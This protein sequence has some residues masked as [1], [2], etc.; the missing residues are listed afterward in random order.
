MRRGVRIAIVIAAV[1]A[2][3]IAA[4]VLVPRTGPISVAPTPSASASVS[5]SPTTSPTAS[6]SAAATQSASPTAA[7]GRATNTVL[8]YSIQ[9]PAPWRRTPCLSSG[10][11]PRAPEILGIDTFTSLPVAEESYGDTGALIN[12]LSVRVERNPNRLTAEAWA[13]SPRMGSS[14]GQRIEPATLD[15]RAGVRLVAELL[16][17]ETTIVPVDDLMY[18]VGFTARP[19]DP[20]VATMRAIIASFTF[21]P[22]IQS[23][24]ATTR[25]ARSAEAVADGLATGFA[26]QDVTALQGLMGECFLSGAE[27][28]GFGSHSPERFAR[29]LREQFAAGTT[30]IV[31]PRP[32]ESTPGF[33]SGPTFSIAT[34][35]TDPAQ[36]PM[37]VDLII[38]ADGPFHYWR[39]TIR[40]Q[41]SP[42]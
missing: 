20:I 7:S 38:A 1:A 12:T 41:Q 24:A 36:Q 33:A 30:V 4:I 26:N 28:G 10:E 9:L 8:G 11:E 27:G 29:I 21:V 42:P 15:G 40:R 19:A 2:V 6:A 37:R 16:Q 25:P 32:I 35:W 17:T 3:V 31:R 23:P 13:N 34:T 5:A 39:G 18:M 22:R 14:Q